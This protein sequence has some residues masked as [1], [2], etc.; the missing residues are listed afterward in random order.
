MRGIMG[1]IYL[2]EEGHMNIFSREERGKE[3]EYN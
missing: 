3:E 1:M 2:Y